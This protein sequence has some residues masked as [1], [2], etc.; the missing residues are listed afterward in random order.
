MRALPL[1]ALLAAA[2]SSP[3]P[4]A[5]YPYRGGPAPR[6]RAADAA[7]IAI[8]AG[9]YLAGSTPAERE[10]AYRDYR[11]TAGHDAA[12]RGRWFDAEEPRHTAR[13]PG[14]RLD[15]TLVT[16]AAYAEFVADAGA[17]P[18]A[19]DAAGWRRQRFIQDY[20]TQVQRFN[21][22]AAG[23]PPGRADHPV[24]LVTW[25]EAA[26]YC[27]WRGQLVGQPRR[28][29]SAA[30]LEK[31]ARG[32]DGRA[33]PW[34]DRFDPTRLDS[35]VAGPVD[36][37]PVGSYPD[38]A[39]P[40]GVLDV[41]GDVFE[42]TSTRWPFDSRRITL[43]GSAWDDFAGVGR[44]AARHGRPPGIRHAIVGFRCAADAVAPA[45]RLY[46]NDNATPTSGPRSGGPTLKSSSR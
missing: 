6:S 26:A 30:E 13:L 23:P 32:D 9:A 34:G 40:Y 1:L 18:P 33:Y 39:G 45:T 20:A 14:F 17:P 4:A 15:R 11:A 10:Q 27:R 25:A 38:G 37:T 41:V 12:R 43:K 28:L 42:W 7:M 2:C 22:T 3:P 24:V 44:G 31:A 5:P 16:N 8:P 46:Q 21:W 35:Q 29:P 19:I 36:T